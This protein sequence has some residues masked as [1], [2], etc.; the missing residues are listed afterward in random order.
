MTAP[1]PH[2][3][4]LFALCDRLPADLPWAV[5]ASENLALR[6]FDVSP[7]DIDVV[8]DAEGV[9]RIEELCSESVVRAVVPPEEAEADHIRS[10]F[11]A[12]SLSGTEVE[13]MGDVEHRVGET[14]ESPPKA[15]ETGGGEWVADPPVA[16]AREFLTVAD[17]EVPVMPL[18][19]EAA[20]YRARGE[21]DRARRIEARIAE[22]PVDDG[23]AVGARR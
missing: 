10:H 13:L 2:R 9:Y 17:R 7:G 20:G 12:L 5:T 11:G 15:G 18:D 21:T 22:T 4:A 23:D 14:T 16:E 1:V 3:E 19:V 6:G 8:S